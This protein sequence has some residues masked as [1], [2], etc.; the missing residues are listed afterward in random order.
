MATFKE[1]F[2][3]ARKAGDKTFMWEGKRYTTATAEE[4][5][6]KDL[7]K[8]AKDE[9]GAYRSRRSEGAN[10]A[11]KKEDDIPK[12]AEKAPKAS[13]KDTSGPSN[14]DR[15]LLGLPVVGGAAGAAMMLSRA[16]RAEQSAR[17]MEAMRQAE[18]AAPILRRSGE[19]MEASRAA[20][21][22]S[23]AK[24]PPLSRAASEAEKK[25]GAMKA[26]DKKAKS[27]RSK[28]REEE[29]IEFR[30][31]GM[32]KKWIGEAIK[33]PGALRKSLGVKEGSNIPQKAM[34]KAAKAPGVTGQRARLAMTL[35]KMNKGKK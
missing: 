8:A 12:S 13:G 31:G 25:A 19:S 22:A 15:I 2:R 35:G 4:K 14:L 10:V 17:A 28:T 21:R 1:A 24:E 6:A 18:G 34:Q 20:A 7:S 23:M 33:K 5:A 16:K 27:A 26:E 9:T 32:A 29:D 30:K 3:D 11:P